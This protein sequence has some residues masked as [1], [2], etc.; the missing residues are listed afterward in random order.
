LGSLIGW[1]VFKLLV[2][3]EKK[4]FP[5]HPY[6]RIHLTISELELI[7]ISATMVVFFTFSTVI[8]L[9]QNDLM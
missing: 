5:V 3:L 8:V 9:L 4:V 7:V 1:G 2:L 6:Q